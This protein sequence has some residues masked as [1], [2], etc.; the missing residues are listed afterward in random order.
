MYALIKNS[1]KEFKIITPAEKPIIREINFL[2]GFLRKKV[3]AL[4]I[5]VDKL[6]II[7]NNKAKK[8]LPK[9]NPSYIKI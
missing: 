5:V 1:T 2:L 6:A 3:I 7:V 8:K 9:N 4:P